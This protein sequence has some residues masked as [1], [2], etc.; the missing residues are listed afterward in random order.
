[1][2]RSN[3]QL[4]YTSS[5]IGESWK[6]SGHSGTQ[7]Y[8]QIHLCHLWWQVTIDLQNTTKCCVDN[9][10]NDVVHKS[11]SFGRIGWRIFLLPT[12]LNLH[13]REVV[14]VVERSNMFFG[15][16]TWTCNLTALRWWE[17]SKPTIVL[18]RHTLC[19]RQFVP[20]IWSTNSGWCPRKIT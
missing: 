2:R 18:S 7:K 5:N 20:I 4:S 17:A 9:F 13:H 14:R 1:M 12:M 6:S 3:M 19:I 11:L 10:V 8:S 15:P 16:F